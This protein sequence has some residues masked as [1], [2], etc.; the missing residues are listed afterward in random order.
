[1]GYHRSGRAWS[2]PRATSSSIFGLLGPGGGSWWAGKVGAKVAEVRLGEK[3]GLVKNRPKIDKMR[4]GGRKST[5]IWV[6]HN[7]PGIYG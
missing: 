2:M 1:M 4:W 3:I 5:E 6:G 7:F